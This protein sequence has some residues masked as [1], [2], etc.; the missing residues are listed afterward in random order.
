[1]SIE[2]QSATEVK[3]VEST[4]RVVS[5]ESLLLQQANLQRSVAAQTARLE[6]LNSQIEEARAQGVKTLEEVT[7]EA[8]EK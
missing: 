3:I 8:K 1:M 2:K 7:L 5:L 6:E 4:E